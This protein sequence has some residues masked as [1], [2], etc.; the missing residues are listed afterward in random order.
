[1]KILQVLPDLS[2]G[3]AE[4]FVTNLGVSL[5]KLGAEVHF[6]LMAGIRGQRGQV[7]WSRLREI[8]IDVTGVEKHNVRSPVNLI[9]L[10]DLIRLWR[11][12]IVQANMYAAEVLVAAARTLSIV[13]GPCYVHRL[14]GTEICGYRSPV[15]VRLLGRFFRQ[16]IA[17]SPAVAEAY[18]DFMGDR[19]ARDIV[20][21]PNGGLL[22]EAVTTTE[23]KKRAREALSISRHAFV[24]AHI[25]RMLGG[26]IGTGFES[27]PKAQD[28]VLKSFAKAF[29]GDLDCVLVLL[30]DG[31]LRSNAEKLAKDLG[32]ARQA[33]FLGEQPEPWNVLKAADVFFFP[34]RHEGL[35]NVLPEAASCGLP[36]VASDIPE[37][38]GISPGDG[39]LLIPADSVEGFAEGLR[40]VA[41]NLETFAKLAAI[42]SAQV[43]E[44]F[45]MEVC[46]RQYLATYETALKERSVP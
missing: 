41:S 26:A 22:Q 27:E 2:A 5:V 1:M 45:S 21:I 20:T 12:E 37:I 33:F 10:I 6:F 3:G 32:I 17:C 13:T 35:P 16:T 29:G 14:A 15:I 19:L 8:G 38:R 23:A 18:R 42:T 11:P 34:S 30:G 28:V 43:R 7:L 40:T 24:V 25:G 9:R 39:W 4:S 44:R 31:P 36:I 46:A